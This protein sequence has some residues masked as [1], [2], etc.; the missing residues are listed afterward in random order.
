MRRIFTL[1]A[2]EPL[3]LDVLLKR[4]ESEGLVFKPSLPKF[5]RSEV[6]D[7]LR[8]RS[9]LGE[10]P[11]K[12]HWYPGKHEPIVDRATWD[13]VQALL[14]GHVY[15]AHELTYAD[16][17]IQCGHCGHPITGERVVKRA[18]SGHKFYVYYRCARYNVPGHPRIRVT[19]A[20]LDAQLFALFDS[21]RIQDD[22]VRDW[23]RAVLASQTKDAQADSRAQRSELQ[24]Q[25]SLLVAQQDR[26]L[27]M[28]L[29]DQIDEDTFAAKH[30]ELRDRLARIKLQ[31]D[32]LDR[33]H[34]ETAELAIKVFEL[35]QTLKNKWI[36]ADD[37]AQRRILEILCLNCR[38]EAEKLCFSLRKPFDA[39]ANGE[40]IRLSRGDR[41]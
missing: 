17:L 38:L 27:N 15:H 5:P 35:S 34:D 24:R 37:A 19:E 2:Y 14:G 13:R 4:L 26:L 11:Y 31:L 22:G 23:F 18:K 8:D 9:Y 40:K 21:I 30:T 39:L 32:V 36:S 25:E 33:S 3:T 28:R 1:Y 29:N 10:I 20:E 12:G 6:H 16:E 7:L 41:I